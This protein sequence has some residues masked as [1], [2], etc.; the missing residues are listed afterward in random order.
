M[1]HHGGF[2]LRPQNANGQT[3]AG[4]VI[5]G[6]AQEIGGVFQFSSR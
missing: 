4:L 2:V 1:N 5:F 3:L 6:F